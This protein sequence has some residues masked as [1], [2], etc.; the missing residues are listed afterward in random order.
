MALSNVNAFT[1]VILKFEYLILLMLLYFL[2]ASSDK[3]IKH[4]TVKCPQGLWHVAGLAGQCKCGDSHNG[5]VNCIGSFLY[6]KRGN[7]M[8]WNNLTKQ[9]ELQ[10]CLFNQWN[11]DKYANSIIPPF[12]MLIIYQQLFLAVT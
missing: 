3:I 1:L 8:T 9:A 11:F 4:N 10:S 6:I 2:P 7:C 5:I 12:L